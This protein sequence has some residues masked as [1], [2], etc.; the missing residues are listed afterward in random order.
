M[1]RIGNLVLAKDRE[2]FF[3]VNHCSK[4]K[5]LKLLMQLIT[6]LGGIYFN[7]ALII[8][9]SIYKSINNPYLSQKLFLTLIS[10]HLIVH[11]LKRKINR[12][13][14][15]FTF[16]NIAARSNP[17]EDYSFPSGH[18]TAAFSTALILSSAFSQI[19]L[20]VFAAAF[21]IAFSRVYLGVHYP[22]D[23]FVGIILALLN[24]ILI[25]NL[26]F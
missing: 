12:P 6:R 16:E 22:S 15:Y 10:S 19:S 26:F 11:I 17:F 3:L 21:L 7:S 8:L 25:I 2:L 14:P 23:V 4:N 1:N 5:Y 20:I 18:T 9:F 13:R 24:Y